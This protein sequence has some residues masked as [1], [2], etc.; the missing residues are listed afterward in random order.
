MSPRVSIRA[1][2]G[3]SCFP[4]A[5][6][7][8]GREAGH[9]PMDDASNMF[10]FAVGVFDE[11]SNLVSALN[12]LGN[13]AI[14]AETCMVGT[15]S[16]MQ[17]FAADSETVR[18]RAGEFK[19]LALR[20]CELRPGRHR[21]AAPQHLARL[22]QTAKRR[23]RPEA[24]LASARSLR[25]AR[26]APAQRG[27]RAVCERAGL[28][29]SAARVAGAVAAHGAYGPDARVHRAP[30]RHVQGGRRNAT[31]SSRRWRQDRLISIKRVSATSAILIR[32]KGES[33]VEHA[34]RF[35]QYRSYR[36]CRSFSRPVARLVASPR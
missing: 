8:R 9:T 21:W 32:E 28:R 7:E 11:S 14:L 3:S 27:G 10:R 15:P 6:V 13:G 35:S 36:H 4:G 25:R 29:P 16:A 20:S 12:E 19:V 34:H 17:D 2:G 18:S 33:H 1:E 24:W 26:R 23:R 31:A 5:F 22:R 30:A